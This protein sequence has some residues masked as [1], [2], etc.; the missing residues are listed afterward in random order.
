[1]RYQ[2]SKIKG[3]I[4]SVV[5]ASLSLVSLAS[6]EPRSITENGEV[7]IIL[8][9]TLLEAFKK[10]YPSLRVPEKKDLIGTWMSR[11]SWPPAFVCWGD[12]NGDQ[13]TDYAIYLVSDTHYAFSIY[14]GEK[15]HSYARVYPYNSYLQKKEDFS[16][17]YLH[18]FPKGKQWKVSRTEEEPGYSLTT[19]RQYIFD[20]DAVEWGLVERSSGVLYWSNGKYE[21]IEYGS[22]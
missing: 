4:F 3:L 17:V 21:T 6:E 9:E 10:D 7:K 12:F 5:I 20:N 8:P 11:Y 1:V 16:W 18:L 14:H 19:D 2:K 13:I 15:N 22:K